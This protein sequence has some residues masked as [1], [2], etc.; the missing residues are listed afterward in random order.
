MEQQHEQA[1]PSPGRDHTAETARMP[2]N[3]LKTA[4]SKLIREHNTCALATVT[5]DQPRCTPL[6]YLYAEDCLWIFSEGGLKFKAFAQNDRVGL[7]VF[8]AYTGF[9]SLNSVQLAARAE[10]VTPWSETY[11]RIAALRNL[12][13]SSLKKLPHVLHLIKITPLE[14][15]LLCSDFKKQ[16]FSPCQHLDFSGE[17]RR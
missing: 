7:A 6:E 2:Q 4:F 9:S 16:G 10:I 1:A 3:Q 14:A 5:G 15:D 13:E 11:L 17:V 8:D 12:S